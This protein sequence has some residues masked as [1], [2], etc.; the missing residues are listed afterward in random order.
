MRARLTGYLSVRSLPS[1]LERRILEE[2]RMGN[3]TKSKVVVEALRKAF[4]MI[5]SSQRKSAVREL[6]GFLSTQQAKDMK[7]SLQE[8]RTV[9]AE[10]WR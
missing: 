5:S 9:E 1:A 10:M 6:A 2:A 7:R 4:G 8:Q 3:A